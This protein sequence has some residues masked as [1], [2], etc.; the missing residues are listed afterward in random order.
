MESELHLIKTG[1]IPDRSPTLRKH[2]TQNKISDAPGCTKTI[3]ISD[4]IS[5][6]S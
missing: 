3:V 2:T 5:K 4:Q 1:I 6:S